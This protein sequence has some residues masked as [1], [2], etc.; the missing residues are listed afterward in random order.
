MLEN[1]LITDLLPLINGFNNDVTVELTYTSCA[2]STNDEIHESNVSANTIGTKKEHTWR[3]QDCPYHCWSALLMQTHKWHPNTSAS[4]VISFHHLPLIFTKT[5][6]T[7]QF[8]IL[9]EKNYPKRLV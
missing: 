6:N 4:S 3:F 8:L 7:A 1:K 2:Y 5:N 9:W